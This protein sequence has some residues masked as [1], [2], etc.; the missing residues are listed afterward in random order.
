MRTKT[1]Y[2]SEHAVLDSNVYTGGGTDDTVA[3]QAILDKAL[4]YGGVHLIMD[5]AALITGLRLHSNTTIECLNKDCGFFLKDNSNCAVVENNDLDYLTIQ[6][7]NITLLGG[8]Y[9][10]NFRGQL[11]HV[12]SPDDKHILG[13]PK[14]RKFEDDFDDMIVIAMQFIGVENILIRDITL[15]NQRAWTMLACNFKHVTIENV[16][17]DLPDKG[18]GENQD[19]FHFW[20]PGQF[21]TIKNISGDVGDDFIALAPDE[22]DNVSS[23]T[24]VL[25]DNVMLDHA[26]Q[27]IRLLSRDNGRLDR[28]MIRNVTGIYRSFGFYINAWESGKTCGNF[29]NIQFENI[30][31][32]PE[33]PN[34]TY[35]TPFLFQVGGRIE[36]LTFR[37]I[38]DHYSEHQR[39][40]FEFSSPFY[41]WKQDE[42][43][44]HIDELTIDGFTM[45]QKN[46]LSISPILI[47]ADV[48]RMNLRNIDVNII[49]PSDIP[50]IAFGPYGHVG[51]M[52]ING[53]TAN[54]LR[55]L[56]APM[57]EVVDHKVEWN[58]YVPDSLSKRVRSTKTRIKEKKP[59]KKKK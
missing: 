41:T 56:T 26:D 40:L 20:G 46:V 59:Q 13:G 58:I 19:G 44:T 53:V 18:S 7:K 15:R 37:N 24:D 4:E 47:D 54:G 32:R 34:Y 21:L 45:L 6:N 10:H 16:I 55:A 5:G 9:N 23:I 27:G 31:L 51:T 29:G 36:H 42:C 28:V 39:V 1:I 30:D 8:T 11:H 17:I 12:K 2:A 49:V 25:I 48:G 35:R 33:A 50:L 14:R 52:T 22:H 3:L 38:Q 43:R 57:K